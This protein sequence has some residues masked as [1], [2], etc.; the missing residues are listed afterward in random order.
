[1]SGSGTAALPKDEMEDVEKGPSTPERNQGESVVKFSLEFV[2]TMVQTLNLILLTAN[3]LHG[4]RVLLANAFD[5]KEDG[6]CL[7]D[8]TT[9]INPLGDEHVSTRRNS[10]KVFE[11]LFLCWCHSPVATFSLCLLARAYGVAFAL[12]LKFSELEVTVGK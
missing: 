6:D 8:T 3:E 5:P 1:M 9:I 12:V 4:L 2:A 10:I 11:T 7:L